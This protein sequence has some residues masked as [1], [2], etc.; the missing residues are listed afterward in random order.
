[1]YV[2]GIPFF[3]ITI[4]LNIGKQVNTTSGKP[5]ELMDLKDLK[6]TVLDLKCRSMKNNLIFTGLGGETNSEDT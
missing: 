1:M 2:L 5:D 3:F 6:D 4:E